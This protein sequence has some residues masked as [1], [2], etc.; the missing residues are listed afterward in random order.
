MKPP[1]ILPMLTS[2]VQAGLSSVDG[3]AFTELGACP[4]CGGPV[5]GYD[6]KTKIFALIH[7]EN[8]TRP[9]TVMV[10]RFSCRACNRIVNADEPFYPGTRVGSPIIDLCLTLAET[11]PANRTAAY[12]DAM[13]I[14]MDRTSCRR[15]VRDQAR[16]VAGSD[17]FGIRLPLSLVSLS[18][19][20]SRA[21]E[22][23]PVGGAEILAACGFPSADRAAL[24]RAPGEK[25]HVQEPEHGRDR[26]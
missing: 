4:A 25:R 13:G 1:R 16:P 11:M 8:G 17:L 21:G 26:S 6:T 12:L 2:I 23:T 20:A 18:T 19:L 14:V 10:R 15:Y 22:G 7:D 24:H 9:I 5:S 3:A